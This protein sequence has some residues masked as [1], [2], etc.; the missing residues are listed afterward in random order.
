MAGEGPRLGRELSIWEA[1]G[2]SVALMAPS[3][4]A[5]INPQGMVGSVGRAVPLTFALATVGVLLVAYTFVRL[6]QKF[7]HSGS[8]YGFVG[9]TLGARPG[10]VAGW[11]LLGTYLFYAV[12]TS[13]ASAR[14]L[15]SFLD[16][17]G[18]WDS[19]PDWIVLPLVG[20]VLLGVLW[21]TISPIRLG[22]RVLLIVEASTVALILIVAVVVLVKVSGDGKFTTSPFTVAPGTD[23]SALFLGVVFGFLS[24]AGFE[25][26]ATLGE[27]TRQPRRDIPR[28]ILGTAI[29]GGVY[30]VFVTWVEVMGFGT[31]SDG[32]AAF[33]SSGSLFGDLG[34]RYVG[35][36]LGDLISLGAA[37]SAFGCALACAV[38]ASR[39]LFAMARDG[40]APA[41]LARVSP[42]R[43]TPIG[44]AVGVVLAAAVIEVLLWLV[45]RDGSDTSLAVFVAA[46][47]IG[48]LV[49]LVVYVLASVGVIRLLF[50][51][52]D[53]RVRTW[54]VI[55]PVAGLIVL[56]YTL[57]RNVIPLPEGKSLVA[58]AVAAVW[59][60]VG[61]VAVLAAPRLTR[62]AG[63][64]LTAD[65]GLTAAKERV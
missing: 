29:F 56:G 32:L 47:V 36:W 19:P 49:L 50:V 54:E 65:E 6:T 55:I 28:A 8:V 21:L 14:F 51:G 11:G 37:I 64:A 40:L 9:A 35:A 26:A 20:L 2:I 24:F 61:L 18:L 7:H 22:T 31:S 62:R 60:L 15:V 38:G 53:P 46:G 52:R 5:N 45:Y 39:L 41:P 10:V 17:T 63:A 42:V 23:T 3:M 12:V 4:A 13:T 59:L 43:R 16:G 48:T 1:V 34:T 57:Y 44:A 25:A 27:E 58:P 30:F 33:G